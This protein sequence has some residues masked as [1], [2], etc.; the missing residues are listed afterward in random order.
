MGDDVRTDTG[1]S[2]RGFRPSL[3]GSRAGLKVAPDSAQLSRPRGTARASAPGRLCSASLARTYRG[4]D[5]GGARVGS[6][7]GLRPLRP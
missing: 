4:Q 2:A 5:F 1:A 6:T 7:V 3:I